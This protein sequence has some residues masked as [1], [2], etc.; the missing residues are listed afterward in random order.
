MKTRLQFKWIGLLI[1]IALVV[2]IVFQGYWLKGV[3]GTLYNQMETHIM[4]AMRIADYKEL[5]FRMEEIKGKVEAQEEEEVEYTNRIQFGNQQERKEPD[6]EEEKDGGFDFREKDLK[7]EVDSALTEL[8]TALDGLEN[9]IIQSMHMQLDTMMHVNFQRYDSLLVEE[10][11]ARNI[12]PHYQLNLMYQANEKHTVFHILGKNHP[13]ME[14]DTT[15]AVLDW[16]NSTFYDYPITLY[17][18]SYDNDSV[19]SATEKN[20]ADD[21]IG[22]PYSYRL[23]IKSPARIILLQM[24]GILLSSFLVLLLIIITFIYMLRTMMRQ[25]TEE[26]LKTDFTNN[27]TH[28]LKT[29]LSISYAAVDSLLHYGEPVTEKQEK[30]LTIV[31]E[32]L[33]YLT[34]LVEQILTLSVENRNTFRL[35]P[36]SIKLADM[37]SR[38]IEQHKVKSKENICFDIDIPSTLELTA[39][40]THLYNMVNNL[41]DNAFKYTLKKPV[42]IRIQA[43]VLPHEIRL[44]VTDNGPGISMTH[45]NRIFDKFYRIPSGNLHN[46][47]GHGLGLYYIKDMMAKHE[48]SVSIDSIWGKGSTFTL[49]FKKNKK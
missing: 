18:R 11:K 4:E 28:E 26:E 49:H 10:L 25:K 22:N 1:V 33:S 20:K 3:Y 46:V 14:E 42:F 40:R 12:N 16:K 19:Y 6:H 32:Q 7:N 48:G 34:G 13:G 23:Y 30:Y 38:L 39:D 2:L 15:A 5:F 41:I 47:K 45:Q 8:L 27:M 21:T 44:S 24:S 9:M 29:P 36:E 43:E 31:K 17:S 35:R 37:I